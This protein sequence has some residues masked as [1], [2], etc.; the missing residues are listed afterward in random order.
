MT[1]AEQPPQPRGEGEIRTRTRA[2]AVVADLAERLADPASVA[3]SATAPG[4]TRPVPGGARLPIWDPVSLTDG[5]PAVALLYAE[6]AHAEPGYRRVAHAHLSHAAA[7]ASQARVAGLYTGHVALAFAASRAARPGEYA[8]VL[9]SIDGHLAAQVP[10]RLRLERERVE[11]GRAGPPFA[12][13]DVIGGVTGVGR[14]LLDRDTE[15]ARTTLEEILAYLVAL[16]RPVAGLPGWWVPHTPY[17]EQPDEYGGHGNLGLAHGVPGPLALLAL[18]WQAG[19]RVPGQDEAMARIAGWMHDWHRV[20]EGGAYWPGWVRRADLDG[21]S[22]DLPR[23]RTAWCY[24]VP[25]AARALQLAG[26]ALDRQDWRRSAVEALRGTLSLPDERHGA[27]DAGLCHGWAGLL[28]LTRLVA[29]DAED[30]ELA[31]VADRLA[32]R[33]L[34]LYDPQAPFGFRAATQHE[35][36]TVDLPGFLEGAAGIA[37]ALHAYAGDGQPATVWDAA[38]LVR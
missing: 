21:G 3:G 28:H 27:H 7:Q 23:S 2:A 1:P 26:M 32:E 13:Y 6:L 24:G 12:A 35:G 36:E 11:A 5:Y 20:D 38:L 22:A 34:D 29:R 17:G 15:I 9:T 37:L 10:A 31:R 30:A 19:V 25:G 8:T 16:T 4:N 18:A 14:H 33:A